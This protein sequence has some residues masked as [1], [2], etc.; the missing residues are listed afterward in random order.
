MKI[1]TRCCRSGCLHEAVVAA[2]SVARLVCGV[3]VSLGCTAKHRVFLRSHK[4]LRPILEVVTRCS[5]G[6]ERLIFDVSH[7]FINTISTLGIPRILG[8]F[9]SL[10]TL[11][12]LP[13]LLGQHS[14]ATP[15]H[16]LEQ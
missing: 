6:L 8:Q 14:L 4:R 10:F 7:L 15:E 11:C 1:R 5:F 3:N 9:Q 12:I 2:A 16:T 13:L